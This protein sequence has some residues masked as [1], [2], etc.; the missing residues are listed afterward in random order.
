MK[1]IHKY[2]LAESVGPFLIGLFTFSLVVLLNRFARLADLVIAKGVPLALVGK[3]FLSLF[4]T[5]LEITLPAALLLAVLLALGR[6]A[7]DSETTA[8]SAAG[9]GMRGV[10]API[11]ALSGTV[12]LASLLIAW[13]GIP[14]GNR[15]LQEVVARVI[16][17]RA[18]A[19][20]AEHVFQE[21]TPGVL[22]YPDRVS[23]DGTRISGV[24]LSQRVEGQ[25]PLLVFANEGEFFPEKGGKSVRLFLTD[26]AIHHEETAEGVY[27]IA[28][29]GRMDFLLPLGFAGTGD[30]E[31]PKR[32]T[33]PQ[34]SRRIAASGDGRKGGA[35]RYHFH[36]RLSL[37]ASCFAFGLFAIP[38]GLSQ[39]ARGK[40][41]ALAITVSVIVFYYM[42]LAAGGAMENR[43]PA[44]MVLLLWLPNALVLSLA[45]WILWRSESRM[46]SLPALFGRG[47]AKK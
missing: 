22:L 12:F 30:G 18:G 10:A 38:L 16:S 14:W 46:I 28:S 40:S 1:I 15:Q 45:C 47:P 34:L 42:F 37:A 26:G 6:L 3:L 24:L 33:L 31:D 27:R 35:F 23:A 41:P 43:N 8:L 11:L 4:P 13:S 36:R 44:A 39:R 7:S 29:F 19:G 20:A 9:V 17:I 2:V 32:L 21:V 5:F 25:D